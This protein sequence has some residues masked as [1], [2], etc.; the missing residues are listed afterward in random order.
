MKS[1]ALP[2]RYTSDGLELSDGS[3]IKADVIVFAT[4]FD[5]NMQHL[6]EEIFGSEIARQ[7][8]QYWSLDAE[9]EIKGAYKPCG[10]EWFSHCSKSRAQM[11]C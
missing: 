2:T 8:G 1:N 10:R 3:H 7:M 11:L 9:G 5:G 4:G 6:V